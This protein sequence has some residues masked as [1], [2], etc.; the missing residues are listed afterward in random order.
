MIIDTHAHHY[1]ER[2]RALIEAQGE[3]SPVRIV[4]NQQ[5]HRVLLFDGREFF[6]FFPRFYDIDVRLADMHDA[7]IDCQVLSIA[8]PMVFWADPVLGR[9]LCQVYND[10]LA[11]VVRTYPEKVVF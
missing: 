4:R 11:E 5:G 6:T 2:F 1:P 3:T 8:P 9:E 7:G 10:E